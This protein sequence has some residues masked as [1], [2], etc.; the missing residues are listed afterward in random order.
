LIFFLARGNTPDQYGL[1]EGG[2]KMIYFLESMTQNNIQSQ[3]AP[4][5]I[6]NNIQYLEKVD[7]EVVR[8]NNISNRKEEPFPHKNGRVV[9]GR[10]NMPNLP[11][12]CLRGDSFQPVLV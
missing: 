12:R 11:W 5:S 1:K 10:A 3:Q 4:S 2:Y 9:G 6:A 7:L 8:K